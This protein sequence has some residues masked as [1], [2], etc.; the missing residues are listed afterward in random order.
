MGYMDCHAQEAAS[1]EVK[2]F[3]IEIVGEVNNINRSVQVS[4]NLGKI[5]STRTGL[6]EADLNRAARELHFT[7]MVDAMNLLAVNGWNL[8]QSYVVNSNNRPMVYWIASKSV[9]DPLEL[10]DGFVPKD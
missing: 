2:K 5:L 6:T 9:H 8:E 1:G 4:L 10:L 3:Y 7:S